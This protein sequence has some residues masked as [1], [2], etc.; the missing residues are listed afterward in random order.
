MRVTKIVMCLMCKDLPVRHVLDV[1]HCEKNIA[2]NILKTTFGEKDSPAVRADLEARGIRPHLHLQRL[3]PN[4]DRY[5]MPDASYVL[6]T[7]DKAKVLQVLKSL[8]PPSHYVSA[9]HKK[10]SKGKLSGL[11][12]HDFH[13]LLQQILPLCFRKVSNKSLAGVVIRLSRVFRKLCAKTVNGGE[14]EQLLADVAET[15]CMLEKEFPASFFDIMS[16]LPNHL[17]EQLFQCG[18]VHTRWMYPYERYFKTLKGYVR[19]LAKPEGSIAQGYQVEEA[20]GFITEYMRD[21]NITSRRVWDDQ[22]EPSMVDE[23]LEG[24]G[25]PKLLSEGLRNAMHDFVLDNAS[26]IEPYRE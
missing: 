20:L 13:V 24:K 11:K 5:Y 14:K 22:E 4:R 16:H 9:L 1:M 15:M 18:P 3:G 10:I 8:R 7:D 19:N 23:I 21:Y 17:V 6:S 26:H 12:S 25:K 2:E